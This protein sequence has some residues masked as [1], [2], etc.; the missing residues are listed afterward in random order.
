MGEIGWMVGIGWL[1]FGRVSGWRVV[2]GQTGRGWHDFD[3]I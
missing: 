2:C 3:T 1:V